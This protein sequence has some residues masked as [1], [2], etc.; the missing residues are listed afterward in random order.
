[1]IHTRGSAVAKRLKLMEF[2]PQYSPE[3]KSSSKYFQLRS[4]YYLRDAK[5][6]PFKRIVLFARFVQQHFN[7]SGWTFATLKSEN[8]CRSRNWYKRENGCVES[9]TLIR[10]PFSSSVDAFIAM[11]WCIELISSIIFSEKE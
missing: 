3:W 1:M 9:I 8:S 10:K 11:C 7:T 6:M 4:V 2:S 5:K